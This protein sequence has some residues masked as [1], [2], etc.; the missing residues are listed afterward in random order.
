MQTVVPAILS[1]SPEVTRPILN[2]FYLPFPS[3]S[4]VESSPS[5]HSLSP[6]S[7]DSADFIK[8]TVPLRY[9]ITMSDDESSAY[10]EVSD[11]NSE[12]FNDYEPDDFDNL[13]SEVTVPFANVSL[14]DLAVSLNENYNTTFNLSTEEENLIKGSLVNTRKYEKTKSGVETRFFD[15]IEKYGGPQLQQLLQIITVNNGIEKDRLFYFMLRGQKTEP[16]RV[17]LSKCLLLCALKWRVL[18]KKNNG[19]PLQPKTWAQQMKLLFSIF[20]KKRIQFNHLTDFNGEG[21]YHAVLKKQWEQLMEM[22]ETF[23]SGIG[24]S[25]FD[26]EADKKIRDAYLDEKNSFNPFSTSDGMSAYDDRRRYL[27]FVL[28][29]YFLLRGRKELAYLKWKQINFCEANEN[30]KQ[31]KYVEVRI[32]WDKGNQLRLNSTTPRCNTD[33][34]P[35]MYPNEN[36]P[37]CPYKFLLFFRGLCEPDQERVFCKEATAKQLRQYRKKKLPY[38][39]SK[40]KPIGE[41]NVD[42]NTKE[43]A[44]EMGFANWEKCTNHG[45]RKLGIT[46]LVTNADKGC[47][48]LIL[49][50]T[51]HKNIKTSLDYQKE[52]PD[53]QETY[54]HSII[55][56]HVA[57][58]PKS[59]DNRKVPRHD[60]QKPP[61]MIVTSEV[62]EENEK[63]VSDYETNTNS[64][65]TENSNQ[66]IPLANTFATTALPTTQKTIVNQQS[67]NHIQRNI[68]LPTTVWNNHEQH[69]VEPQFISPFET[70]PMHQHHQIHQNVAA[71]SNGFIDSAVQKVMEK[72]EK[73]KDKMMSDIQLLKQQLA[74]AQE[75]HQE[76]LTAI[77]EKFEDAKQDL[78]EARQAA[79]FTETIHARNQCLIS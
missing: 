19:K 16:K 4:T 2:C 66:L 26:Y 72:H 11:T 6:R 74:T 76:Q 7:T 43:F 23:A 10:E 49:K 30:G 61:Q 40:K 8:P 41:N 18:T 22:D 20:K 47:M 60:E 75:K 25:S 50:T 63:V 67:L 39:Y 71:I 24:T 62:K 17:I 5:Y 1:S 33:L 12:S 31:V 27:I 38:L 3:P 45:N 9:H 21:E 46:T 13:P 77:K 14:T 78:R 69:H 70:V 44:Q 68:F 57:P 51:R 34:P 79:K 54:N 59:P 37:L 29:R 52:N 58:P 36:D 32:Q 56:K 64:S 35:R 65:A 48:P 53:M 28:G 15:T 55:G 42:G 73:E